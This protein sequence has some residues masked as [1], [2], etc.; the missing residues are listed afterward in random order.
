MSITSAFVLFAVIWFMVFF[1]VLPLRLKT[2]GE[3]GNIVPGT[4]A[5]APADPQM[6]RRARI[7]TIWAVGLWILIGG[8][9]L[10]GAITVRDID[11]L[12]RMGPPSAEAE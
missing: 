2:Q 3:D 12:N 5:S 6:W 9:I 4:H 8:T 10:S 11:V 1:V 7:T